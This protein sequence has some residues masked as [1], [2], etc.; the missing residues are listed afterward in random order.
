MKSLYVTGQSWLHRISPATKIGFLALFSV[1]LFITRDYWLL[2]LGLIF[3]SLVLSQVGISFREAIRRLTPVMITIVAVA[4]FSAV[5]AT[6]DQAI[7]TLL[8][9]T[10]LTVLAAAVTATVSIAEFIAVITKAARPLEKLG[11]V[12]AADI[13]LAVGLVIRFIPEILARYQ[14]LRDAHHARGVKLRPQTVIVPLIILTLKDADA[15]ADA[16]DARGI[17]GHKTSY[18]TDP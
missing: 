12:N 3:A 11:L 18:S 4:I 15:I 13:G 16:I 17:R 10:S 1:A 9:L 8:R 6:V 14:A 2:G 5:F 7:V